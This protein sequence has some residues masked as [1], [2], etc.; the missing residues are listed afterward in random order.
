MTSIFYIPMYVWIYMYMYI[1]KPVFLSTYILYISLSVVLLHGKC[2]ADSSNILKLIYYIYNNNCE[3][4]CAAYCTNNLPIGLPQ[5][6]RIKYWAWRFRGRAIHILSTKDS[7]KY[8]NCGFSPSYYNV[9]ALQST[10]IQRIPPWW[11]C[12]DFVGLLYLLIYTKQI[13]EILQKP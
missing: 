7:Q 12:Y 13:G 5:G 2:I 8:I 3:E 11:Y 1:Y 4:L 6:L 10:N 9:L